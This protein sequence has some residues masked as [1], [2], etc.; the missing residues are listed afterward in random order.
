MVILVTSVSAVCGT[1][2]M[3]MLVS[4]I[5]GMTSDTATTAVSSA[6]TSIN[7]MDGD[8]LGIAVMFIQS[9]TTARYVSCSA[10]LGLEGMIVR[11]TLTPDAATQQAEDCE[12]LDCC[13][14]D[15]QGCRNQDYTERYCRNHLKMCTYYAL[16]GP[17][18]PGVP[19]H[20][21]GADC[22]SIPTGY[23]RNCE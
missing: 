22:C 19:P 13:Y 1:I 12:N 5:Y 7:H 14:N 18:G 20:C 21:P 9:N 16:P 15:G 11:C 3:K 17:L 4:Y 8:V 23:G 2:I 10:V 6:T